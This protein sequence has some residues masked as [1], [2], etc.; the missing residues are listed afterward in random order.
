M[1]A[2]LHSQEIQWVTIVPPAKAARSILQMA[3]EV[4]GGMDRMTVV[5]P[6]ARA[7]LHQMSHH[8][9]TGD[10]DPW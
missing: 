2:L 1:A 6:L 5:G 4:P 8:E 10:L 7:R 3:K 9:V